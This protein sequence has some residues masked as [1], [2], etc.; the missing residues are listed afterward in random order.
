VLHA[1]VFVTCQEPRIF[2]GSGDVNILVVDCGLKLNQIRCLCV[3]G[4]RV[5]IVPWDFPLSST[6]GKFC[7]FMVSRIRQV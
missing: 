5:K 3:R 1:C 4:A 7:H 2:N 6:S